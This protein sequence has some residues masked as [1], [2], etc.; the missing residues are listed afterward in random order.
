MNTPNATVRL[1]LDAADHAAY[2]LATEEVP[3]LMHHAAQIFEY[4]G[5]SQSLGHF[6]GRPE[7]IISLC[8]LIGRAFKDI[9]ENEGEKLAE[10]ASKL[11]DA[12]EVNHAEQ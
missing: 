9:A 3:Y 12:K 4:L 2:Q 6:D 7:V 8:E 5:V 11:R 1:D 10:L